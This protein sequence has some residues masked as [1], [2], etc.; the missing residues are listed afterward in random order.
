MRIAS[1]GL[2]CIGI[3]C[4]VI[5]AYLALSAVMGNTLGVIGVVD[6]SVHERSNAELAEAIAAHDVEAAEEAI[7]HGADVNGWDYDN[8]W[9]KDRL[10]EPYDSKPTNT[11][12]TLDCTP[13]LFEPT[14]RGDEEMLKA[15]LKHGADPNTKT[16]G[17]TL[18]QH[19][20]MGGGDE[21][22]KLLISAGADVNQG[23]SKG[24]MPL[25]LAA[26]SGNE[27]AVEI[28]INSGAYLEAV[29]YLPNHASGY[30]WLTPLLFAAHDKE[31]KAAEI[32][33]NAG[34]NVNHQTKFG[35]TALHLAAARGDEEMVKLL[36]SAGARS[37]L[38]AEPPPA[39]PTG[40]PTGTPADWAEAS[41]YPELADVL[42]SA[43]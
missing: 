1:I 38:I 20:I 11:Y 26:A 16:E 18:L 6:A 8:G 5:V 36:L 37:N 21:A 28:L 30:T 31:V 24:L 35:A 43:N 15:L 25:H 29:S 27:T 34:A 19:A 17:L 39:L 33:I 9:I 2:F 22:L 3:V 40:L 14:I 12:N 4:G 7:K 42:R 23:S 10:M 13:M 41:G 32:L